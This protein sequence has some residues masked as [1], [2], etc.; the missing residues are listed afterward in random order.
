MARQFGSRFNTGSRDHERALIAGLGTVILAFC[1]GA[2]L[3]FSTTPENVAVASTHLSQSQRDQMVSVLVPV[4]D[5][6]EGQTLTSELFREEQRP[7]EFLRVGTIRS[8]EEIKNRYAMSTLLEGE[9][10]VAKRVTAQ[11]R[12]SPISPQITKGKSAV[13][14]RVDDLNSASGMV[15]PG[16]LVDIAWIYQL[17]DQPAISLIVRSAPVL[18]A[19]QQ[20]EG[21]FRLGMPT[22][23]TITLLVPPAEALQ[24]QLAAKTGTLHLSL[25]GPDAEY[26]VDADQPITKNTITRESAPIAKNTIECRG[27]LKVNGERYC[28]SSDGSLTLKAD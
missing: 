6:S 13:T 25:R 18:A 2:A 20:V 27:T 10:L 12:L 5:I 19:D 24:I 14:I 16:E 4:R 28:V 8:L 15:R 9:P 21:E 22:P 17:Q 7:I 3:W 26:E 1:G 23:G 11:R